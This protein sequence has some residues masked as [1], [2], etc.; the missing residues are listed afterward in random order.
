MYKNRTG[1]CWRRVEVAIIT[2]GR[3]SSGMVDERGARNLHLKHIA[4]GAGPVRE[5]RHGIRASEAIERESIMTVRDLIP[6][7][8]SETCWGARQLRY[9]G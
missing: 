3:P 9:G 6:W 8:K 4:W 7:S 5:V 2:S 1:F